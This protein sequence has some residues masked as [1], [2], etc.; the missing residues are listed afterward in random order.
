GSAAA[1]IRGSNAAHRYPP[2]Q[3]VRHAKY[4]PLHHQ[5]LPPTLHGNQRKDGK[6]SGSKCLGLSVAPQCSVVVLES[7]RRAS[8]V[9]AQPQGL[10][11]L[12]LSKSSMMPPLTVMEPPPCR[13]RINRK[14]VTYTLPRK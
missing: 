9:F 3:L 14:S 8:C 7:I 2:F 1:S 4:S 5:G 11:Q 13:L 10:A 6:G 12:L